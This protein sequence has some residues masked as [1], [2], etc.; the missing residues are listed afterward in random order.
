MEIRVER[1]GKDRG[2]L[3]YEH[4]RLQYGDKRSEEMV[5]QRS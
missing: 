4:E 2:R 5:R 1:C 3:S